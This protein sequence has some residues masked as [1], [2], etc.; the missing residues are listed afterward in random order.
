MMLALPPPFDSS[1]DCWSKTIVPCALPNVGRNAK[2]IRKL[3]T[4][5]DFTERS[6]PKPSDGDKRISLLQLEASQPLTVLELGPPP[7]TSSLT[8]TPF[9]SHK[10]HHLHSQTS[11]Q[12]FLKSR[13][14]EQPAGGSISRQAEEARC[15]QRRSLQNHWLPSRN[16]QAGPRAR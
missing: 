2:A 15:S 12:K 10:V 9:R 14:I 4:R 7:E 5:L 8:K 16:Y 3:L 13:L 6:R 1:E 11:P